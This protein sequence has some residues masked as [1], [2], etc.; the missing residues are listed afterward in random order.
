MRDNGRLQMTNRF[1][2]KRL[3]ENLNYKLTEREDIVWD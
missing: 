1:D 2:C 3:T